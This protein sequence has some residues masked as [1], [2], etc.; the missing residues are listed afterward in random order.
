VQHPLI[1]RQ[2][3]LSSDEKLKC[4]RPICPFCAYCQI[5]VT[6][7]EIE[8]AGLIR[9]LR[10][11]LFGKVLGCF[12]VV[13]SQFGVSRH[14]AGQHGYGCIRYSMMFSIGNI[15]VFTR[16][17]SDK[18]TGKYLEQCVHQVKGQQSNMVTTLESGGCIAIMHRLTGR[19]KVVKIIK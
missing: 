17:L 15:H 19:H 18:T 14:A 7:C 6:W 9:G 4:D 13:L 10:Y 8:E 3:N 11:T 1:H 12:F 5:T 2:A 16:L